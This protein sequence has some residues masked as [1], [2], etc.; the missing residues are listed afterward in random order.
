MWNKR[1]ILLCTVLLAALTGIG[2]ACASTQSDTSIEPSN[3]L[4]RDLL[5]T[6]EGK[7][8][9]TDFFDELIDSQV[10]LLSKH[11]V[12][13]Q[14]SPEDISAL[15]LPDKD[16]K[17]RL[18]AVFT[19]AR[20]ANR[21]AETYPEYRYGI[22]TDFIW[23]LAHAAPGLSVIINPGWNL[24]LTIPSYGVLKMRDR[25]SKRIQEHLNK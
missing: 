6:Q 17:S 25:Y 5:A 15:V 22:K 19:S 21:V 9:P 4:E 14:K 11:D 23:V 7:S 10:V 8:K 24:G 18:L 1:I 20:L 2:S 13:E 16:G 12:L 3:Q